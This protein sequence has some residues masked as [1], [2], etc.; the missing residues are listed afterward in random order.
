MT[1]DR[2]LQHHGTQ[3]RVTSF[4][5]CCS[6]T[7]CILGFHPKISPPYSVIAIAITP[8][9]VLSSVQVHL[10]VLYLHTCLVTIL[11]KHYIY[12]NPVMTRNVQY[13][14]INK[15]SGD[16]KTIKVIDKYKTE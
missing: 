6:V 5:M 10:K 16:I 11:Q 14:S 7:D 9:L 2:S 15:Q 8:S 12:I 1:A 4:P 3:K 13:H